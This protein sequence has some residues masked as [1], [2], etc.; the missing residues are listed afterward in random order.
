MNKIVKFRIYLPWILIF[1][2]LYAASLYS[3]I[4]LHSIAEFFSI[5]IAFS[6]FVIAWNSRQYLESYFML[7]LGIAFLFVG[8]IDLF[9]T[10]AF[11]GLEKFSE[12][13]SNRVYQLWI[14]ARYMM[15]LSLLLS[16]IFLRRKFKPHIVIYIYT[17]I[18][19]IAIVS[20]IYGFFPECYNAAGLT[21]FKNV[22]EIIIS[23]LLL[24]FAAMVWR[25][26]SNFDPYVYHLLIAFVLLATSSELILAFFTDKMYHTNFFGLYLKIASFFSIYKALIT[27]GV[28]FPFEL[29]FRNLKNSEKR[30][31]ELFNNMNDGVAIYA[32]AKDGQDWIIR[33]INRAGEKISRLRKKDIV[34]K[35]IQEVFP[36]LK[37]MGMVDVMH[38]VWQTGEPTQLG[39]TLYQDDR[40]SLWIDN[41]VYKL[42]SGEIVVVYNDITQQKITEEALQEN[43]RMLTILMSNLPGMAYRC[44]DDLDWTMEFVSQGCQELTGY[45]PSDLLHNN[46]ISFGQIVHPDDRKRILNGIQVNE[47]HQEPFEDE[48]RIITAQ[49][50]EKW[51]W[52]KGTKIIGPDGSALFQEG[53]ITDITQRKKAEQELRESEARW[54]SLVEGSPDFIITLGRDLN[55]QF[56]NRASPGLKVENMIGTPLYTYVKKERQAE[57]KAI[58]ESVIKTGK[59]A[60]YEIDFDDPDKTVYYESILVPRFLDGEISG[61]TLTSRDITDRRISEK[62]RERL[63]QIER[64]QRLLAETLAEVTLALTSLTKPEE[65]LNEILYQV[66]RV[67]PYTSANI[68][69]LEY[70]SLRIAACRGYEPGSIEQILGMVTLVTEL[71]LD[72][73]AISSKEPV[74]L[75]D[76]R[77]EEK[78]HNLEVTSWIRS[79]LSMPILLQDRV[80]GMLR[81]DGKEPGDFSIEDTRRL[82]PLVNAAAIA[83]ENARLFQVAQRELAERKQAQNTLRDYSQRLEEMVQERTREL[84]KAQ[85]ELVRREKLGILG[86]LAGGLAHEL[87]NPLGAIKNAVYFIN[88]TMEPPN[89]SIKDMLGI[90]NKEIDTSERIIH[91][92]LDFARTREPEFQPVNVNE[93]VEIALSRIPI[94][95]EPKI[96]LVLQLDKSAPPTLADPEQLVQILG[97]LLLNAVQAMPDG[98]AL[99]IETS[100]E[101][102]IEDN[103]IWPISISISDTGVGIPNE[104]LSKV[105]D[106]LF[107]TKARGI[108]LGLALVKT[109]LEGHDGTVE[110]QSDGIP[111]QGACFTIRLPLINSRQTR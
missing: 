101:S 57:I 31:R 27:V 106:P 73:R 80:L 110:V 12:F 5:T 60:M 72:G 20:I 15:S 63:L 90:I 107:S 91:S 24:T 59:P 75:F 22:S 40:L 66:Q 37:E 7:F 58:H 51:V 84:E 14:T 4:L 29:L 69:L 56:T 23:L 82:Q 44:H 6:I 39:R 10:L 30:F 88:L 35:S 99:V 108:G 103:S 105:F 109:L 55:I 102:M 104:N 77:L 33:D 89:A 81:L 9:H 53:F 61:I 70:N 94:P 67:V 74:L 19:V 45:K 8:G 38:Q 36:G 100:Y 26:R 64:E 32:P 34:G 42:P 93:M 17:V 65:V 98:G 46:K 111:G 13:D 86:Q 68:A 52:E 54:R 76:T 97:N 71:P 43:Q 1:I 18:S 79:Y 21:L 62:E 95:T 83:L 28:A 92:L 16:L 47:K 2:G 11:S 41:Q 49:G 87:R 96:E 50:K 25:E 3:Q 48:Y 78:W 85:E